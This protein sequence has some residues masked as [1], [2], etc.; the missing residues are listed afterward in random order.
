[1]LFT[2]VICSSLAGAVVAL[3]RW[4]HFRQLHVWDQSAVLLRYHVAKDKWSPY[5]AGAVTAADSQPLQFG[6]GLSS[7]P[8]TIDAGRFKETPPLARRLCE[9]VRSEHAIQTPKCREEAVYPASMNERDGAVKHAR[10]D[11]LRTPEWMTVRDICYETRLGSSFIRKQLRDRKL[12]YA[13]FGTC[14]R[15]RRREYESWV[16]RRERR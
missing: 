9:V 3:Q 10:S 4:R 7:P 1:M 16:A 14:I 2:L 5:P 15:I 11:V 13:V 12:P 8:P 6:A